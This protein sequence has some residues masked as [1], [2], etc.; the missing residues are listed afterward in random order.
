MS[1]FIRCFSEQRQMSFFHLSSET[2]LNDNKKNH[3][4]RECTRKLPT[5]SPN[6][7]NRLSLCLP[8]EIQL[9]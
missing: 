6:T 1:F 2:L 8:V 4:E 9:F 7:S 5:V 3:I